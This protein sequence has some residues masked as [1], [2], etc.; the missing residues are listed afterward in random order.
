MAKKKA[1]SRPSERLF[2]D[3]QWDLF[4]KSYVEKL[5]GVRNLIILKGIS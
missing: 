2:P 3:D 4:E 1:T 5:E